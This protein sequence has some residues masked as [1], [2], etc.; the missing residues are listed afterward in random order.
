MAC[1]RHVGGIFD[2]GAHLSRTRSKVNR[3]NSEG[4]NERRA[5]QPP[6]AAPGGGGK[7]RRKYV[8]G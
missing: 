8:A 4:G 3:T 7:S 1:A 2:N 6:A 5:W